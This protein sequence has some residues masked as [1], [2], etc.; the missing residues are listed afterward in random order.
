MAEIFKKQPETTEAP[1]ASNENT[2]VRYLQKLNSKQ[3][4]EMMQTAGKDPKYGE[5]MGALMYMKKTLDVKD[6]VNHNTKANL[7]KLAMLI[8][9]AEFENN[10][11]S[12]VKSAEKVM[13]EMGFR[14]FADLPYED[15]RNEKKV[16]PIKNV[17][18]AMQTIDTS[19]KLKSHQ[20]TQ[21]VARNLD[22]SADERQ[23]IVR[24]YFTNRGNEV[25]IVKGKEVKIATLLNGNALK[26]GKIGDATRAL[27]EKM[28]SEKKKDE[29]SRVEVRKTETSQDSSM[30][31]GEPENK[32]SQDPVL[33]KTSKTEYE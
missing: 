25:V 14:F 12:V 24:E 21:N 17:E 19:M 4:L 23:K 20:T 31:S 16:A 1:V 18:N 28:K 27:E 29:A 5:I 3:I 22:I 30:K 11:E 33:K 2:E 15:S 8:A 26:D 9:Y 6:E 7:D 13:K 10:S 32:K